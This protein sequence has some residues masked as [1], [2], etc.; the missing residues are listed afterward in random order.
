MVCVGKE[1]KARVGIL[2]RFFSLFSSFRECKVIPGSGNLGFQ[3]QEV[4][5]E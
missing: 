3:Q 1:I 2:I 5:A 4:Y